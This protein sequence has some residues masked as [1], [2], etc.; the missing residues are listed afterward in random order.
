MT[1][2]FLLWYQA[3][4]NGSGRHSQ[5][6]RTTFFG[7]HFMPRPAGGGLLFAVVNPTSLATISLCERRHSAGI[8]VEALQNLLV[9]LISVSKSKH[10]DNAIKIL[11]SSST[12]CWWRVAL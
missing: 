10:Q 12:V 1:K 3:S 4:L 6:T 2:T 8:I 5:G 9:N 7:V 11:S